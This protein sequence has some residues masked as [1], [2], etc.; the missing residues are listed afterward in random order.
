MEHKGVLY[1]IFGAGGGSELDQ[2]EFK[3]AIHVPEDV[4]ILITVP[5][6]GLRI[7]DIG[8]TAHGEGVCVTVS[9]LSPYSGTHWQCAKQNLH[10]V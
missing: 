8:D 5:E 6:L 2:D 9:T 7:V 3:G 10:C 4:Q 1:G